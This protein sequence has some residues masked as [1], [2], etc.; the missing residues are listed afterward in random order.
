VEEDYAMELPKLEKRSLLLKEH[1]FRFASQSITR[2]ISSKQL[3]TK[4]EE[5]R[6]GVSKT[7]V[8]KIGSFLGSIRLS[9]ALDLTDNREPEET[10]VL[11]EE[12]DGITGIKIKWKDIRLGMYLMVARRE[13]LANGKSDWVP[14]MDKVKKR[15]R[16]RETENKSNAHTHTQTFLSHFLTHTA[17]DRIGW[18]GESIG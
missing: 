15:E 14:A 16:E 17:D 6:K 3:E 10:E 18:I 8:E 5:I 4:E 11:E 13:N 9:R 7:R 1:F 2:D 12:D